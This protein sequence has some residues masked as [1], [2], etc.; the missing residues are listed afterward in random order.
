MRNTWHLTMICWI[1]FINDGKHFKVYYVLIKVIVK[2]AYAS[3]Y[4]WWSP[5]TTLNFLWA[6]SARPPTSSWLNMVPASSSAISMLRWTS[7]RGWGHSCSPLA[8]PLGLGSFLDSLPLRV[9]HHNYQ[10]LI[11]SIDLKVFTVLPLGFAG[12]LRIRY[13]QTSLRAALEPWPVWLR[14]W[15]RRR[16]LGRSYASNDVCQILWSSES[17]LGQD[18]SRTRSGNHE[19]DGKCSVWEFLN[20]T[21]DKGNEI[22]TIRDIIMISSRRIR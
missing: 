10:A 8:G 20:L 2:I 17:T 22:L 6:T 7:Q 4:R 19:L 12:S 18:P 14:R 13:C 15:L 1:C 3:R 11:L 16:G 5:D 21:L 9:T